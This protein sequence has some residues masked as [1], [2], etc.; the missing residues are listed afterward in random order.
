[1]TDKRP[2]LVLID[3]HALAYRAYFAM[4]NTRMSTSAGEPT[5]AVYGFINMLLAVWKEVEPD[6]FIVTFDVG[7][8]FRHEMYADYKATRDKMPEDL[9]S[10]I[11][12]IEQAVRAFNMPVFTKDGFEADD[13][14]G[15]LANQAAAQGIEAL[16]V[17]GDR[18]AFQLVAPHIKVIY[19]GGKNSFNERI[20][21]DEAQVQERYGL[22]PAQLIELKGLTGDSSDNIPGVKGIG[23]KGGA[24]LIQEYGSLENIYANLDKLSKSVA[25]KLE[26]D[27]ANAFLSR[28]LGRIV[29]DVEGVELN[30]QAGKTTDF[31]LTT[32]ANLFVEL[33]FNTIFNRIPGAPEDKSPQ[34]VATIEPVGPSE[35]TPPDGDYHTVDTPAALAELVSK[36]RQSRRLSVDVETDST[37][38]VQ[39]ALVGIAITPA[40]GEGYYIPVG[41]GTASTA[42][43]EPAGQMSLF[44]DAAQP[45]EP[46][47]NSPSTIHHSQLPL[48]KVQTALAPILADAAITKYMHNA[49]FDMTVLQRH[50]LPVAPPIFDT[51]IAVWVSNNAPGVRYGLKELVRERLNIQMTEI[52]EL[53]G[54]GKNQITMVEVPIEQATPYAAADVDMTLRLADDI[55]QTLAADEQLCALFTTLEIPLISVL[56][57]MELA[58]IKLDTG[59]LAQMGQDMATRLGQLELE[60]HQLAGEEFNVNST[61]QLSDILFKKLGLPSAGLKKTKSGHFSTAAGVLEGLQGLHPMVDLI[62]EQRSLAKLKSTYVDALPAIVNPQTGRVHTN[63]NQVGIATGRLSSSEP[64]LQ[65][66]PIRTEQGREIRRAF[67]AE[68]GHKLISADYSQVELRILAHIA[69]DP[70]LLQAFANDEDIHAATAAAVLGK[71]IDQVDKYERRIAKAVNFGLIYGQTAFGLAQGTGMSRDAARQFIDTYFDKYPGVKSYIEATQKLAAEQGYVSTL[72]GRRRDFSDLAGLSGAQRAR[73]EREA[74]NMPIQ[75]TAADIMK[76]AMINLHAALQ[77]RGMA[78]RILLQVHDELVLEAPEA[79]MAEAARLTRQVMADAADL[80]VPLKVDVEVGDNWLDMN[81][82]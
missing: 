25:G 30:L 21:Y 33:E 15:T 75:G 58:G 81:Q 24:K 43:V 36:L 26:A 61:Q 22:T 62:L 42:A 53:I 73:A 79:E 9:P 46:V 44:G 31:N 68:A 67:V 17:T 40:A 2:T 47:N 74:I 27:R 65:N 7:D 29:T 69:Q 82:F 71:P 54:S 64:N 12:R 4:Q 72:R 59:V 34:E 11:G 19:P 37:D 57:D 38:E 6:Y 63:Y 20:V 80:S 3:G 18:D 70:G 55:E 5:F 66:I 45:E 32:V 76:Q 56:K 52:K 23:E 49:K 13:L 10:Q 39:T 35:P 28:D 8:T 51:M 50:G 77:A 60:I 78:S 41:H 1:M 48:N 14:L 16:I